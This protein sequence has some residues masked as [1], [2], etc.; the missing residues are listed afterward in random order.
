MSGRRLWNML[1]V[2]TQYLPNGL[3]LMTSRHDCSML[4][5]PCC[6]WEY[7]S[8]CGIYYRYAR[9]VKVN[10]LQWDLDEIQ[11]FPSFQTGIDW[12]HPE[13][14]LNSVR[15]HLTITAVYPAMN[16]QPAPSKTKQYRFNV[17]LTT[18]LEPPPMS[19]KPWSYGSQCSDT[20]KAY[21]LWLD[22]LL[23]LHKWVQKSR[24][25]H[26]PNVFGS[27]LTNIICI[28]LNFFLAS[29]K[30]RCCDVKA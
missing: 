15:Q 1:M 19:A 29:S 24:P 26:C 20:D 8:R 30:M 17:P 9:V 25:K 4:P 28:G 10:Q 7:V 12:F 16:P 3:K 13:V 6:G 22:D 2:W 23:Q 27:T 18:A 5:V 21:I 11:C 14:S